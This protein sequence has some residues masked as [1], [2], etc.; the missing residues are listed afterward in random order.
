MGEV[1]VVE[2]PLDDERLGWVKGLYGRAD[3]KYLRP[4]VLHHLLAA[5]PAGPALHAFAVDGERAVA[6]CAVV[7]MRGRLGTDELRCGK[8]EAL[9]VDEAYRGRRAGGTPLAIV[10]L[11]RLYDFADEKG[12]QLLH[13]YVQPAVGRVTRFTPLEGVGRRSLVAVTTPGPGRSR[14]EALLAVG[15][16]AVRESAYAGAR[17]AARPPGGTELRPPADADLDLVDAPAPPPG[18]WTVLASDAWAWHRESPLLRVLQIHGA[19]GCRALVQ[20]PGR[21]GESVR[22]IGWRPERAGV[23]PAIQLLGA[24]GRVARETG[25]ATLRFQPWSA[26]GGD[27]ALERA[28][29]MLGFVPRDDLTTLWVRAR[30]PALV[31][32]EAVVP[33]PLFSLAF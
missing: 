30:D 22:L 20:L 26:P 16:R 29:R 31:R 19:R 18:R 27:G 13:A 33:T 17:A 5:S 32:R 6:H 3:A 15:Q 2:G 14:A 23:L 4:E 9:F 12:F 24:A 7:P 10:L 11:D 28:C 21:P 1:V 25:A 8:L